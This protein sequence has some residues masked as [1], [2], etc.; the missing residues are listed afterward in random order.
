MP[1][2]ELLVIDLGAGQEQQQPSLPRPLPGLY[3]SRQSPASLW[4]PFFPFRRVD[5]PRAFVKAGPYQRP[6][7]HPPTLFRP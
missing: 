7:P 1:Q 4:G 6:L 5:S 2:S 3:S